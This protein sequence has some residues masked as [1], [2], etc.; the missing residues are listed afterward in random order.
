MPITATVPRGPSHQISQ[1]CRPSEK[2]ILPRAPS[3][4]W[5][6]GL[7]CRVTQDVRP[8]SLVAQGPGAEA[9]PHLAVFIREDIVPVPADERAPHQVRQLQIGENML[10]D[11]G[12]QPTCYPC[13]SS[14]CSGVG[15]AGGAAAS[16]R[17][18]AQTGGASASTDGS[19]HYGPGPQRR[20]QAIE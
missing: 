5:A 4:L 11:P 20:H 3:V 18:C 10:Q 9:A 6:M 14:A 17:R 2:P 16:C 8:H 12:R 1:A 7:R 19:R 13:A 15:R